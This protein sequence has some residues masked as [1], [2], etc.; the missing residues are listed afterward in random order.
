MDWP[1]EVLDAI[2]DMLSWWKERPDTPELPSDLHSHSIACLHLPS[3][4]IK[5]IRCNLK[6][7]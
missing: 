5:Q 6:K 4:Y 7:G 2:P 1:A 3:S